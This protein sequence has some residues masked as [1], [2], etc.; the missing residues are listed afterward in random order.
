MPGC[1]AGA[2]TTLSMRA[3]STKTRGEWRRSYSR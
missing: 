1:S 3:P 2:S